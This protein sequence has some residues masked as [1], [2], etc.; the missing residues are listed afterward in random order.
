MNSNEPKIN[1][2][3]PYRAGHSY[4]QSIHAA[5]LEVFPL[6]CPV[7]ELDWTPGWQPDWVISDSGIAEPDC[8]FQTPGDE[9]TPPATWFITRHDPRSHEVEM[10]KIIPGHSATKLQAA[11]ETDGKG[12]TLATVAYQYTALGPDGERFVDGCTEDW[13]L[14]FMRGWET[15]MNHYLATGRKVA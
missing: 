11:L 10:I 1:V 15:A 12:G 4:T 6:L 8:I 2:K 5:P 7:R 3:K 13:Y 9:G 14:E